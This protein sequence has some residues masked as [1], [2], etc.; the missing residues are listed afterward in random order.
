VWDILTEPANARTFEMYK[1]QNSNW[2]MFMDV[3]V[4]FSVDDVWFM[5]MDVEI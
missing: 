5:F 1:N 3:D 2:S 4:C